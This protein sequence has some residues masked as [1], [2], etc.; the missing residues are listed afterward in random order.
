MA[1]L[2]SGHDRSCWPGWRRPRP[3]IRSRAEGADPGRPQRSRLWCGRF[4]Q[5]R[6]RRGAQGRIGCTKH[7][8]GRRPRFRGSDGLDG[9]S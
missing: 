2:L 3:P 6:V 1:L 4:T 8:A 9:R 5:R 7:Q